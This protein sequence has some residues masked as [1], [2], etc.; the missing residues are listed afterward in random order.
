MQ[1]CSQGIIVSKDQSQDNCFN[2]NICSITPCF[3][4][5]SYLWEYM[6]LL[7]LYVAILTAVPSLK[8]CNL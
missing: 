7:E 8:V 3:D 5:S 6:E 2:K 1:A 4:A